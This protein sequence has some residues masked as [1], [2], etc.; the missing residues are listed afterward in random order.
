MSG[1][2]SVPAGQAISNRCGARESLQHGS[3]Q[4]SVWSRSPANCNGTHLMGDRDGG[5]GEASA[6]VAGEGSEVTGEGGEV[7]GELLLIAATPHTHNTLCDTAQF[8]PGLLH[9]EEHQASVNH[10]SIDLQPDGQ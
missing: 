2:G 5:G 9:V 7:A 10:G 1:S 3:R 4:W 6:E 8:A